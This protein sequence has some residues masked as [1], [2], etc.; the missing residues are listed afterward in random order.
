[1]DLTDKI[2]NVSI[3]VL[4]LTCFALVAMVGWDFTHGG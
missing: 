1:M 4:I 3:A 2:I